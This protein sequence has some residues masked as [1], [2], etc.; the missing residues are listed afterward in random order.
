M[1]SASARFTTGSNMAYCSVTER[2]RFLRA[3]VS[4]ADPKI[5]MASRPSS[6]ARSRPRSLGTRAGRRRPVASPPDAARPARTSSAS[7]IC[8][9]HFAGTKD[10]VSIVCRPAASRRRMNSTFVAA[11]TTVFSFCRPSRGPTS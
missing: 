1:P 4:V 3:N 9:T 2:L 7:P 8:G 5:A 6:S 10:V 11:G